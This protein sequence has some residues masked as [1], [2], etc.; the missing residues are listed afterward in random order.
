M[1]GG[2]L[3]GLLSGLTGSTINLSALDYAALLGADVDLLATLAA[4]RTT[5]NLTAVTYEDVLATS[6]TRAQLLTAVASVLDGTQSG[7]ASALRALAQQVPSGT[8]RLADL[9]DAGV[10]GKQSSG[11]TGLI[12]LN[13]FQL[14]SSALQLGGGARQVSIDLG[15]GLPGL[16]ST[17][18][19]VAIGERPANSPMIAITD[20]G[21][22]ILRTAQTRVFLETQLANVG[23]P[24]LGTLVGIRLPILIELASAQ[25]RLGGIE[26]NAGGNA[27][28][29]QAAPSPGQVAIAAVDAT[30]LQD[31]STPL[32]LGTARLVDLPLVRVE[33]RAQIDLGAA[34]QWQSVRFDQAAITAGT[35]N[36]VRSGALTQG[37]AASLVSRMTLNAQLLGI[38]PIPLTGLVQA[39]GAQLALVAP[40]LDG[41]INTLTG[42]LGIGIGEADVRVTGV[43]CG[44]PAL[45][46]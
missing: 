42:T 44:Q 46:G 31:F 32:T 18:L 22:P 27:V 35:W 13:V 7:A 33:G 4:L 21:Q 11:G 38:L 2:L 29:L 45:V 37:V 3:N 14:A 30:R 24:G 23:L 34:E 8:I 16:A 9:V 40:A 28:T 41:L 1:N 26:C 5:A 39:V 20:S 17:R 12:R 15:A 19:T 43:R 25:A 10:I 36:T 6:I